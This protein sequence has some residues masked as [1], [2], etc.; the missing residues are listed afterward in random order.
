MKGEMR[1][2]GAFGATTQLSTLLDVVQHG[3]EVLITRRG[4]AVARLVPTAAVD[5]E[6]VTRAV[7]RLKA[8]RAG[9]SL[10]VEGFCLRG[11]CHNSRAKRPATRKRQAACSSD[12][13]MTPRRS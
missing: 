13:T 6:R 2:V 8:L 12:W 11:S 5:R 4:K 7:E 3:E 10:E 9:N 1:T